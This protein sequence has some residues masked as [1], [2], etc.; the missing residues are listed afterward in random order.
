MKLIHNGALG[1]PY[2]VRAHWGEFLPDWHPWEDFR[3]SYAARVDLGGGVLLTLCHPLDYL[4]WIFGEVE[5]T[6][7]FS[8]NKLDLNVDSVIEVSIRFRSGVL[9]SF[10][11]DYLQ[12]PPQHSLLVLGEEGYLSWDGLSGELMIIKPDNELCLHDTIP[13]GFTRNDLFKAELKH[14]LEVIDGSAEA[15]CTL[16][17][18]IRVQEVIDQIQRSSKWFQAESN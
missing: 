16:D 15:I 8:A 13:E 1:V 18:G 7:G 4:F 12:K 5:A 9:G 11:L 2:S 3:D 6:C 10:H 17:Q 14:F